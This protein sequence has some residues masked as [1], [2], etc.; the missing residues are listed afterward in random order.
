MG[1]GGPELALDTDSDLETAHRKL[2]RAQRAVSM[3]GT[4][5]QAGWTS[6]VDGVSVSYEGRQC[7]L[8]QMPCDVHL[9]EQQANVK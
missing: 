3:A 4:E 5:A 6:A 2:A 8:G 9:L 7:Y 1:R